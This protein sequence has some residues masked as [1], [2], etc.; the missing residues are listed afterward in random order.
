MIRIL[1][2]Q[3]AHQQI[4][5]GQAMQVLWTVVFQEER[6]ARETV[7]DAS[8]QPGKSLLMLAGQ[9]KHAGDLII[10]AVRMPKRLWLAQTWIM[11][12]RQFM[13]RGQGEKSKDHAQGRKILNTVPL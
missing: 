10:G 2:L 5:F 7:A 1:R 4:K 9:C 8:L 13:F 6:P 11:Q 3:R 12:L